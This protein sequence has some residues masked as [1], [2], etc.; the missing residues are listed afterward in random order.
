MN[1]SSLNDA[2]KVVTNINWD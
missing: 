1:E 2:S